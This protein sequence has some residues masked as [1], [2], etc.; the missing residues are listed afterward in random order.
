MSVS[1]AANVSGSPWIQMLSKWQQYIMKHSIDILFAIL[2]LIIGWL[3]AKGVSWLVG[4]MLK[5]KR[6]DETLRLF[7]RQMLYI[8]IMVFVVIAALS[9]LGVQTTSLVAVLGATAIAIAF[10]LKSSL[11]N[12]ACGLLL[13]GSRPFKVGQFVEAGSTSGTV[14]RIGLLFTTLKTGD[15][16][17]VYLPNGKVLTD[18]IINY[19]AKDTRRVNI[20]V[21]IGYNDDIA[22]AKKILLMVAE[23]DGRIA[24][25]PAPMVVVKELADSSV[26][27]L[28][29]VWTTRDAY[30][31]VL[32]DCNEAI[33][34]SLDENNINIPYPQR[35]LHI[36]EK[37]K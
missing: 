6:F 12:F 18:K 32:Y 27:L 1:I 28:F 22:K 13:I 9:Q 10:S 25:E 4:R 20:T 26:N 35:D 21:G 29:R 23:T 37:K 16:Q 15:N 34:L 7:I 3:V 8:L 30:W 36:Y 14:E 5:R 24:A 19:G 31:K 33:K 17:I 2:I 11:S